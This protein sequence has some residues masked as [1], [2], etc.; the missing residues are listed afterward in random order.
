MS[1]PYVLVGR[2]EAVLVNVTLPRFEPDILRL[3]PVPDV[4]SVPLL[5]NV[6]LE[7]MVLDPAASVAPEAIVILVDVRVPPNVS[8]PPFKLRVVTVTVPEVVPPF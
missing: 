6:P 8:V 1:V 7:F 2:A 5:V 4:V 3:D